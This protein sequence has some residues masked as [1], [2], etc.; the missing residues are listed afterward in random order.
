MNLS[1]ICKSFKGQ[2]GFTIMEMLA[3]VILFAAF[4]TFAYRV[5]TASFREIGTLQNNAYDIIRVTKAGERWRQDIRDAVSTPEVTQTSELDQSFSSVEQITRED[6]VEGLGIDRN[7][8]IPEE[9][10]II[11]APKPKEIQVANIKIVKASKTIW[12]AFR[13]GKVYRKDSLAPESWEL[14]LKDVAASNMASE[15]RGETVAWS[16][17]LELQTTRQ[18]VLTRP[19]FSFLAVPGKGQKP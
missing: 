18:D 4:L 16:W 10:P 14:I 19:L 7:N 9:L 6:G 12:Y 13:K 17:E 11:P 5:V 3:Y 2:R 15:S 8:T 1:G